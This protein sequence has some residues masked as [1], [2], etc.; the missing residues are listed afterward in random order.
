VGALA[1]AL[2]LPSLRAR[3]TPGTQLTVGSVVLA[4]VA[5]V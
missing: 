1:A 3:L 4:G 2:A 5:L